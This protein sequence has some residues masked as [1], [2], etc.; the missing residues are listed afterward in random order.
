MKKNH[1]ELQAKAANDLKKLMDTL[2]R[3][4]KGLEGLINFK[5]Q[6][7]KK[8]MSMEIGTD[9]FER[10]VSQIEK[11]NKKIAELEKRLTEELKKSAI[12]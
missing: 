9:D 1:E 8:M 6:G 5:R 4:D 12:V 10:N 3:D 2:V 7:V 11:M